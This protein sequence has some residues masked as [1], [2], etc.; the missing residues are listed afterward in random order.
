MSRK[1][2]GD[3]IAETR[4]ARGFSASDLAR[5]T[6]VTPTAVWNWEKNG[7]TPRPEALASIAK[8][9]AVTPEY[10]LTGASEARSGQTSVPEVINN[11]EAAIA[12]LSG[13][14]RERVKIRVEFIPE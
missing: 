7:T 8:A 6:G 1:T 5:L 9:L 2:I 13:M 11:A 14:P 3:R 4:D 12:E 10:I